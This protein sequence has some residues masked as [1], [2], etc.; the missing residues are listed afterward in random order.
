MVRLLSND[1]EIPSIGM[2]TYPLKDDA[3]TKA[4]VAA[5]ACGYRSFDTAKAYGN[6]KSLG[7][8][9]RE[10]YSEN[11][12]KRSDIF[13]TSKI[14]ENLDHG[15]PDG[16]C[17]YATYKNEKKNIKD[18]VSNQ[19][20]GILE[21]L[22]TDYL[23]LLL[24]HWPFPDYLVEIWQAMEDEYRSGSSVDRKSVV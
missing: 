4:V 3:L 13:I 18:I 8:A 23:D 6:E 12:L 19:L 9:L 15:I 16:K 20:D 2:G 11:Q 22:Q 21:N 24:I 5:T 1:I 7:N 10:A 14:G 17:F